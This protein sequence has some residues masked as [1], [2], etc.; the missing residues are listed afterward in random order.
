M[1]K[2]LLNSNVS[3]T[4]PYNM[5]NCSPLMAEI[6]LGVW[7]KFQW[8]LHLGFITAA[9]SFTGSQPNFAQCLAVSWAHTLCIHFWGYCP[10]TE[11]CQVQNSLYIKV[12]HFPIL[13][14]LLHGTPAMGIS[15]TLR[16]GT[17]NGIMELLQRVPP[18]FGW[19]A[20]T[21]GIGPHSSYTY[22]SCSTV[23]CY[24]VVLT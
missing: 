4:C 9:T 12:L 21:F 19:A 23:P 10:L 20:I 13:A 6:G 14:A 17:R 22:I 5:A 24:S 16:H 8:V 11:F 1:G 15:Q 7:G 3:S 18:I 2:Q